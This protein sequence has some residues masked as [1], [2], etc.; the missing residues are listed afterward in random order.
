MKIDQIS[1]H[2]STLNSSKGIFRQRIEMIL[3]SKQNE[4]LLEEKLNKEKKIREEFEN[5]RK[6]LLDYNQTQELFN[7]NLIK[8]FHLIEEKFHLIID[9]FD[10]VKMI[11]FLHFSSLFFDEKF[12]RS[13]F[14][15]FF[16]GNSSS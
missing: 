9:Q 13:I 6:F 4:N 11:S 1:R 16:K 12:H 15:Y 10:Q 14:V 2:C 5:K 7:E 3:Q 8:H